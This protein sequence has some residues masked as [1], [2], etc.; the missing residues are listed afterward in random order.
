ML[1]CSSVAPITSRL[2]VAAHNKLHNR[3]FRNRASL[4]AI[5]TA[6]C[7][8]VCFYLW[9][10]HE[11]SKYR[12]AQYVGADILAA[13]EAADKAVVVVSDDYQVMFSSAAAE[14][15]LGRVGKSKDLAV[16]FPQLIVPVRTAIASANNKAC[17]HSLIQFVADSHSQPDT[18]LQVVVTAS[19]VLDRT[20]VVVTAIPVNA[21]DA[22]FAVDNGIVRRVD[23]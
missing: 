7:L 16:C 14:K 20:T 11:T 8:W 19:R 5:A 23:D 3:T 2:C 17:K 18:R 4:V 6:V 13:F 21:I 9:S 1:E 12:N 15:W 22:K 10:S